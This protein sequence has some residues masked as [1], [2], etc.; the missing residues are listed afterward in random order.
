M[1]IYSRTLAILL[2]AAVVGTTGCASRRSGPGDDPTMYPGT[3]GMQ[4]AAEPNR[5]ISEQD[6]TK[7]I[8]RDGGNLL[9]K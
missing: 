3:Y 9:C 8:V 1:P 6:C 4:P 5:K 7:R 2:A